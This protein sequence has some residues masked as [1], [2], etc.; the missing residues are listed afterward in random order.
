MDNDD[1]NLGQLLDTLYFQRK[2]IAAVVGL[3]TVLGVMYVILATPVYQSDLLIQIEEASNPAK[4]A[5]SEISAL[6]E[7]KT[8]ASAEMEILRSRMVVSH[9]IDRLHL[10]IEAAPNYFPYI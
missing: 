7:G 10:D 3:F 5:L 8:Q 6:Y 9:A 4:N 2:L 1:I